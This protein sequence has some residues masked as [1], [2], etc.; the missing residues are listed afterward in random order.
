MARI[1]EVEFLSF[2]AVVD[3]LL[4]GAMDNVDFGYSYFENNGL[5]FIFWFI[6]ALNET[7]IW[8]A[9]LSCLA[10]SLIA[11]EYGQVPHAAVPVAMSFFSI[12]MYLVYW[13]ATYVTAF[14]TLNPPNI[15]AQL[16]CP[17]TTIDAATCQ[18]DVGGYNYDDSTLAAEI[19]GPCTC[20]R[21]VSLTTYVANAI[22]QWA[23]MVTFPSYIYWQWRTESRRAKERFSRRRS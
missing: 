10:N 11:L 8:F 16:T 6:Y 7:T 20:P 14:A 4:L 9:I 5:T 19:D 15:I 23:L 2:L 22:P 18:I 13:M 1:G 21:D 12:A 17:R 3:T